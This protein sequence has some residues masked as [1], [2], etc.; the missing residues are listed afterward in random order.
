ME[1]ETKTVRIV[2]LNGANYATWKV[3]CRMA[4]M[5]NGV[6]NIVTE[7]ETV[8]DIRHEPKLYEKYMLK[9]DRA[10][11]TIV[12]AVQ[13]SLLYFIGDPEDPVIVWKKLADQFQKKTWANK[14][15]LRRRLYSLK[16]KAG[17]SVQEHVK[18]MTEIFE[19]LSIIGDSI[20]DEDRVIHLLASL[21]EL[22]DMLVTVFEAGTDVPKLEVVTVRLLHEENKMKD[23]DTHG[24]NSKASTTKHRNIET[25]RINF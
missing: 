21:P 4:L 10:L 22:F 3:Q 23:K 13:T 25:F 6:W 24:G 9:R 20:D 11:S 15:A 5:R 12:L 16:M 14:L 17:K 2:P 1:S 19:E 18:A 8:P 7:K